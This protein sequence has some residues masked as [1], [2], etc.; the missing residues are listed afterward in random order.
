[1]ALQSLLSPAVWTKALSDGFKQIVGN[2]AMICSACFT[3][4]LLQVAHSLSQ[5]IISSQA[6]II[7]YLV[8]NI[9]NII[10]IHMHRG[11]YEFYKPSGP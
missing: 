3:F 7:Q 10:V 4:L 1:M 11:V 5:S 8:D 9:D 6:A 2:G